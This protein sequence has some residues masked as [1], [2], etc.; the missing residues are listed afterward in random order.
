MKT[1]SLEL[2]G[3]W[4]PTLSLTLKD[5]GSS[6]IN[7]K[8]ASLIFFLPIPKEMGQCPRMGLFLVLKGQPTCLVEDMSWFRATRQVLLWTRG[9]CTSTEWD[10]PWVVRPSS[11]CHR[12]SRTH[13]WK[14]APS[15]QIYLSIS[16]NTKVM[17][18]NHLVIGAEDFSL[19]ESHLFFTLNKKSAF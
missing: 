19:R 9:L 18:S 14:E 16:S 5:V 11:P 10:W 1:N 2:H 4:G 3:S 13:P 12:C 6:M 8:C 7:Q 15:I 17:G